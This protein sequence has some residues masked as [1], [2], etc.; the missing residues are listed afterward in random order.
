M[1]TCVHTAVIKRKIIHTDIKSMIGTRLR[2]TVVLSSL[3]P[4]CAI[5]VLHLFPVGTHEIHKRHAALLLADVPAWVANWKESVS[6]NRDNCDHKTEC[7]IVQG[8]GNTL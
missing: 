6:D 7:R 4:I 8:F 2:S 1:E 3:P 5:L